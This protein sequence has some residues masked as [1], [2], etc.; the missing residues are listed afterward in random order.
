MNLRIL[1]T[2]ISFHVNPCLK[3]SSHVDNCEEMSVMQKSLSKHFCCHVEVSLGSA[4]DS[5]A[6]GHGF[7][8]QLSD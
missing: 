4:L 2:N 7:D 5:C 6:N 1:E 3:K 8:A